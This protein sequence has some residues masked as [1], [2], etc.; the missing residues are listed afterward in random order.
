MEKYV[1]S[2]AVEPLPYSTRP[3]YR[4]PGVSPVHVA[5]TGTALPAVTVWLAGVAV[6]FPAGLAGTRNV[7]STTS[8]VCGPGRVNRGMKISYVPGSVTVTARSAHAPG[9]LATRAPS[10]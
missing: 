5:F 1:W 7:F 9:D 10:L 4:V 3:K 8:W 6:K 2:S